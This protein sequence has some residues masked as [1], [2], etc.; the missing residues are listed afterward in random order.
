MSQQHLLICCFI[1][2][3]IILMSHS[4]EPGATRFPKPSIN[5]EL[6]ARDI[7]IFVVLV[8]KAIT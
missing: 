6:Q 4:I 8:T 7:Y 5:S 2:A 3:P 1:H